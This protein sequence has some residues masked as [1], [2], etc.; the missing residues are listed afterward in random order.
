MSSACRVW[1]SD[2]VHRRADMTHLLVR[3]AGPCL[4]G[5]MPCLPFGHVYSSLSPSLSIPLLSLSLSSPPT[6]M[7][8]R[9]P[10]TGECAGAHG[11]L[12]G[13]VGQRIGNGVHRRVR[14]P[15]SRRR[16]H[17]RRIS[18]SPSP[19]SVGFGVPIDSS[20]SFASLSLCSP[21]PMSSRRQ[22]TRT[23]NARFTLTSPSPSNLHI[24]SA[25]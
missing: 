24:P 4:N 22:L 1:I 3:L 2:R 15:D 16:D 11:T 8:V 21:Q 10:V 17:H 7:D 12:M 13:R 9:R 6:T 18:S 23:S 14:R 19:P 25:L 5:P 20:L